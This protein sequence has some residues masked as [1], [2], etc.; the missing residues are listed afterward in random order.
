MNVAG[1]S[2]FLTISTS[3]IFLTKG[4]GPSASDKPCGNHLEGDFD[5][6]EDHFE[7]PGGLLGIILGVLEASRRSWGVML[8]TWQVILA[9]LMTPSHKDIAQETPNGIQHGTQIGPQIG[10]PNGHSTRQGSRAPK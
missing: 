2:L 5:A 4:A 1:F 3:S 7:G 9:T 10:A 8:G 6:L